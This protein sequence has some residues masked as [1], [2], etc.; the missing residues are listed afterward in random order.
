MLGDTGQP[1]PG[2][3]AVISHPSSPPTLIPDQRTVTP[4]AWAGDSVSGG[5][6]ITRTFEQILEDEKKKRNILEIQ[7]IKNDV[8]NPDGSVGKARNLTYKDMGELLFDILQIN[9][10]DCLTF[11]F[12]TGR[13]DHRVIKFK[14]GFETSAFV[15]LTPFTFKD[16]SVTI[17][18]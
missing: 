5:S 8:T 14:P 9:P 2:G 16:H 12:N 4:S 13:Y 18:K 6:T 15:K 7:L 3:G 10:D 1:P 17:R 11:N